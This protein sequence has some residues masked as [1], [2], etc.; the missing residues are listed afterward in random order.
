MKFGRS[1]VDRIHE[2]TFVAT[3]DHESSQSM[4]IFFFVFIIT[5]LCLSRICISL[6]CF[7]CFDAILNYLSAG[8]GC[9]I[10]YACG[11]NEI[12]NERI[13]RTRPKNGL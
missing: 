2:C 9:V 1:T 3:R 6:C 8:T 12:R 11:V 10:D 13:R 5:L 7:L 4:R